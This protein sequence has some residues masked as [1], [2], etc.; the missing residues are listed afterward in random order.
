MGVQIVSALANIHYQFATTSG[1][2][3]QP[4]IGGQKYEIALP[5]PQTK[6]GLYV[7]KVISYW[8]AGNSHRPPTWRELLRVLEDVGQLEMREQ[9]EDY[10]KGKCTVS[11]HV[12]VR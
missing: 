4:Q 7:V 10:L 8:L 3:S 2:Q 1:V 11:N 9:I 6:P 5:D 12:T